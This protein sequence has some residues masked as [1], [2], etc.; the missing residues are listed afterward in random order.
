M[1]NAPLKLKR[2]SFCVSVLRF[3]EFMHEFTMK[4]ALTLHT[5]TTKF[6]HVVMCVQY[7]HKRNVESKGQH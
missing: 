6:Y 3:S 2:S 5:T 1:M 7:E 4:Y